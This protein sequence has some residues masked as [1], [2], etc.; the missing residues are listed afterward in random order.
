MALTAISIDDWEY[1]RMASTLLLEKEEQSDGT[2]KFYKRCHYR[3]HRTRRFRGMLSFSEDVGS[4][5]STLSA[6]TSANQYWTYVSARVWM[7]TTDEPQLDETIIGAGTQTQ[8]WEH[9]TDRIEVDVAAVFN[10]T[11]P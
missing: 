3:F 6:Y 5:G 10:G 9:I 1:V 4:T 7:L 8:I 2:V 11:A